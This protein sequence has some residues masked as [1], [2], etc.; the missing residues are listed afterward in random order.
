MTEIQPSKRQCVETTRELTS[1]Q[2]EITTL[3]TGHRDTLDK[4]YDQRERIIKC[5]RDITAL[6][7]KM[8][9]SL[10]RITQQDSPSKVFQDC[11]KKHQQVLQ[12]FQKVSVDLQGSDA[13]KYNWQVT[14]G[15]QEY[16]EAMGLWMFLRENRLVTKQ[17]ILE[18]LSHNGVPLVMVTDQ[19]FILGIADLPGEV[20]R[21]CINSIG[22][23]DLAAVQ[24]CMEFLRTMQEGINLMMCGGYVKDLGKKLEVLD[25]SLSKTERAFYSMAVRQSEK[26]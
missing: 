17:E 2:Q 1:R 4:H 3:F 15:I 21:H 24:R 26:I 5:S 13:Y 25:S 23:G 22:K 6:S 16:I 10:L 14:P 11:E 19:D 7:K 9:F 18:G 12:L 8:V 20:N